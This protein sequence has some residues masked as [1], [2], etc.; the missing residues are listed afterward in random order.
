MGIRPRGGGGDST[1]A[2]QRTI[3]GTRAILDLFWEAP[4]ESNSDAIGYVVQCTVADSDQSPPRPLASGVVSARHSSRAFHFSATSGRVSCTVAAKNERRFEE[5]KIAMRAKVCLRSSKNTLP[6]SKRVKCSL[7][8]QGNFSAA[9]NLLQNY[10]RPNILWT[11]SF[12]R[13][14]PL[15]L[16]LRDA[17]VQSLLKHPVKICALF[18]LS[19]E[20]K[21]LVGGVGSNVKL[22][23]SVFAHGKIQSCLLFKQAMDIRLF[24][25]ENKQMFT[26]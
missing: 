19:I 14:N 11:L 12:E 16:H 17:Y 21:V 9:T 2:L 7:K 10:V 6:H 5:T 15:A 24:C 18:F 8:R 3:D 23:A 25:C 13:R 4:A 22:D 20:L 26:N 1:S